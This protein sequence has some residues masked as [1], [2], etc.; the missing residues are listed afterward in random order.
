[1]EPQTIQKQITVNVPIEETWDVLVNNQKVNEWAETFGKGVHAETDW[2]EGSEII[3][4]DN[5]DSVCGTGIVT[6]FRVYDTIR[7]DFYHKTNPDLASPLG[8][9]AEAYSVKKAGPETTIISITAG[10]MEE[11]EICKSEPKWNLALEKMKEIAER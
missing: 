3:W 8:R 11:S 9:Y 1:M 2:A 7:T 5:N 10:P 6:S 4:K